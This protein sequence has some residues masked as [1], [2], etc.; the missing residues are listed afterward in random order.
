[1]DSIFWTKPRRFEVMEGGTS[2]YMGT[3]W[4]LLRVESAAWRIFPGED[5]VFYTGPWPSTV[6]HEFGHNLQS[7]MA[8]A[9]WRRTRP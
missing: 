3:A 9:L 7:A 8:R 1:M 2:Y 6:A 5:Y 4:E